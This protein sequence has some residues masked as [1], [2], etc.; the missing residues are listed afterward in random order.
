MSP[1]FYTRLLSNGAC[2]LVSGSFRLQD[3][4]SV[5]HCSCFSG[6]AITD[7]SNSCTHGLEGLPNAQND[8]F[9]DSE[10]FSYAGQNTALL[11]LSDPSFTCE[12]VQMAYASHNC[13]QYSKQNIY[14]RVTFVSISCVMTHPRNLS[15]LRTTLHMLSHLKASSLS[16]ETPR[17][18]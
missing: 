7:L 5:I 11:Q 14:L 4:L 1:C 6:V 17:R 9:V 13:Q 12:V 3:D 10:L 18:K 16:F 8:T 15:D 2:S